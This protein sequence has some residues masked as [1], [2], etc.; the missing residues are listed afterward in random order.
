MIKTTAL[1]KVTSTQERGKRPV[2]EI[3]LPE[4]VVRH[5]RSLRATEMKL[6]LGPNES[7]RI[8]A[9]AFKRII[10]ETYAKHRRR[11]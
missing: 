5:I 1:I 6:N 2:V 9:E 10:E 8:D 11:R 7:I 4:R 3:T